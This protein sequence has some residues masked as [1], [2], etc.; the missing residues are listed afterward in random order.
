MTNSETTERSSRNS[1]RTPTGFE[2]DRT[3]AGTHQLKI[4][5]RFH[6]GWL[7][8]LSTGLSRHRIS[9]IRGSARKVGTSWDAGFEI[10]ATRFA[11]DPQKL[12]YL[13][14]AREENDSAAESGFSLSQ[15]TLVPPEKHHG[16]LYLEVKAD[17][18]LGFLGHLLNRLAFLLL[19]PEEISIDT[20]QGRIFDKFWI[21]GLGGTSPSKTA[22]AALGKK[23]EECQGA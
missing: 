6:P 9:I 5:G 21:K 3:P 20:V 2:I 11:S 16:A 23:L 10:T 22:Q 7:G 13:A 1:A 19:F 18:Q 15:F 17:D 12:D 14:L 8:A 4:W